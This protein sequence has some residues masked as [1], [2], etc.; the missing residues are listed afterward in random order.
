VALW[1][2]MPYL[3]STVD[4]FDPNDPERLEG[5]PGVSVGTLYQRLRDSINGEGEAASSMPAVFSFHAGD[6]KLQADTCLGGADNK[7]WQRFQDLANSLVMP[8]FYSLGGE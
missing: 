8:V 6:I 4:V 1:G 2:D 5:L 7:F 3:G